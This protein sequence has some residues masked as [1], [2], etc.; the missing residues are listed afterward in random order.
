MMLLGFI[1]GIILNPNHALAEEQTVFIHIRGTSRPPG[2][3]PDV[4][5][6]HVGT[7]LVF[8]NDAQP[9]QT[10]TITADDQTFISTPIM[11]G[12]QWSVTIS[13]PGTYSYHALEAT[14]SLVGAIIVA[15]A[16]IQ[17]LPTPKP[18]VVATQI[19]ILRTKLT[20]SSTLSSPG[21]EFSPASILLP[22]ALVL[23]IAGVAIG[24]VFI[25]RR[26]R[27]I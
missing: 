11:S 10:Y 6:V 17:L 25:L 16:S 22:G 14:Q 7:A 1:Y 12:Q 18:G 20:G 26:R 21:S 4:V 8:L 2:F 3:D 23:I 27:R 9:A 5:T 24:S 13:S 15:P 19:A